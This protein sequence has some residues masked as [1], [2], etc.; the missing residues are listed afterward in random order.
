MI[1][2][3]IMSG[4]SGSRLWPLS[5]THY[6]KQFISLVDNRTMFQQTLSRL[7]RLEC[8]RP[9]VICNEDHRFMVAEQLR[10]IDISADIILEP[11]GRNTAPAIAL[12]ALQACKTDPQ[13]L[14]LVLAADHVIR[15]PEA[16]TA[17]VTRAVPLAK[18]GALATFGIVADKPETGYG[19]IKAG[20][21]VAEGCYQVARFVE[22]PDLATAES[23][24]EEG[25]YSWNSGMFLFRADV[26]LAELERHQSQMLQAC[27]KALQGA[28]PDLD[29]VRLDREA[30]AACPDDSIDYAV[31]EKT[32]EA[33]VVPMEAGWSDVGSWSSLWE[34]LEQDGEGNVARG[35]TILTQTRN[36]YVYSDNRLVATVGCDNLVVIETRDAV[37]VANKDAVQEVKAVV[38]TLKAQQRSEY[39]HHRNEYRHWGQLDTLDRD[40]RFQVKRVTV[41][42]GARI[43]LQRH[44]NR[45]EHW[46]V[47]SGTAQIQVGE[48]TRL[49]S[50]NQSTYIPVGQKHAISNPGQIPLELIEIHTGSYLSEDDIERLES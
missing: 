26:Y 25:S 31:M 15:Q 30:F 48:E 35:D 14:L 45:A 13:S 32:G 16:F 11:F 24:L 33:V 21:P 20:E 19:Y 12:A 5:R 9:I 18:K 27:Q 22:K 36:S 3:V 28:S 8:N 37:L 10:Q 41:K 34:A 42:P 23:Y 50:E 1:V 46:V 2:P 40:A 38:N 39:L 49:L 29:F 43:S 4:G 7:D 6:P 47:V 44:Y 17:A